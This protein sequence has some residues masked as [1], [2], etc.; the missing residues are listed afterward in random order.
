[1]VNQQKTS[2]TKT[3]YSA[4]VVNDHMYRIV[5]AGIKYKMSGGLRC[6]NINSS[7]NMSHVRVEMATA[8]IR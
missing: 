4:V 5:E 8:C 1:M 7:S 6:H 2:A 3:A